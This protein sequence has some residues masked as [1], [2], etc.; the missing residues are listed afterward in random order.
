MTIFVLDINIISLLLKNDKHIL[1][2]FNAELEKGNMCI[3][4]P[5]AYYE[6]KRGLLAVNASAQLRLFENLCRALSIG[7]MEIKTWDEAANLYVNLRRFG[8]LIED[9]DLFIAAFCIVGGYTLVTDNTKHFDRI[10]ALKY[11][12]WKL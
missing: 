5:I 6:I 7:R 8:N 12:N 11:V 4:P 10:P 9:A 1:S 2:M 3:I